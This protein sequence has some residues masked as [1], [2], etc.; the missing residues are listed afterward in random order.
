MTS[1]LVR[2]P[3]FFSRLCDPKRMV[4]VGCRGLRG[5]RGKGT[6]QGRGPS[7]ASPP[8]APPARASHFHGSWL[9]QAPPPKSPGCDWPAGPAARAP[10][11]DPAAAAPRPA[12]AAAPAARAVGGA[13]RRAWPLPAARPSLHASRRNRRLIARGGS[14]AGPSLMLPRKML[15]RQIVDVFPGCLWGGQGLVENG[16]RWL[17]LSTYGARSCGG[18]SWT[19]SH[20]H[21]CQLTARTSSWG[22]PPTPGLFDPAPRM[23]NSRPPREPG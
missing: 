21:S 14:F 23:L 22:R 8:H 13:P 16:G 18:A 15:P 4:W 1:L 20:L 5:A 3:A 7:A 2:S 10:P 17:E 6:P 11:Q 9:K 12:P 19:E